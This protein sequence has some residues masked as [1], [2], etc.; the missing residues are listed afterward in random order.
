MPIGFLD[1]ALSF[2]YAKL[3][4]YVTRH[5][6]LVKI[7]GEFH[8]RRYPIGRCTDMDFADLVMQYMP[9]YSPDAFREILEAHP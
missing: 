5:F 7:S 2:Q 4:I 8:N 9:H 6:T 3:P 1:P